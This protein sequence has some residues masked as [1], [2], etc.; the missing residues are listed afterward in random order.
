MNRKNQVIITALA[1]SV[2][3]FTTQIFSTEVDAKTKTFSQQVSQDSYQKALVKGFLGRSYGVGGGKYICNTYVEKALGN[4]SNDNL[5]DKESAFKDVKITNTKKTKK[6]KEQPPTSYDWKDYKVRI[7]YTDS[8]Y[9]SAKQKY[10]WNKKSTTT[11]LNK[12]NKGTSLNRLELGDVLTYGTNGGHVALYFGRYSS[13]EEVI[14]RLVELGI[15][16]T[17]DLKK[18]SDRYVNKKGK[19][20]VREYPNAGQ[21]WRVH[22]TYKGLM[23]DNAIVSKSSNGTSSFG[24][25]TKSIP[26]GFKVYS[27]QLSASK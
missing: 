5:K 2:S 18:K 21:H 15:Y 4:I 8:V 6:E 23:I 25:W 13:K 16:K 7:T 9:D 14:E 11:L 3:I 24:K 27:G 26:S 19:T 22:A 10:C 17:S 1:L 20:I 12:K